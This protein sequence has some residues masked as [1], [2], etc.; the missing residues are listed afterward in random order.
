MSMEW[1]TPFDASISEPV[2]F[3]LFTVTPTVPS[4]DS[5][6]PSTDPS[7]IERSQTRMVAM[8]TYQA[9]VREYYDNV[10]Y[11]SDAY[12][13]GFLDAVAFMFNKN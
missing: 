6:A 9:C 2:N 7:A 8:K 3:T 13:L 10:P 5:S 4:S 1:I 12:M 11:K